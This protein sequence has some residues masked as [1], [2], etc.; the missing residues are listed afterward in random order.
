MLCYACMTHGCVFCSTHNIS[1]DDSP[2]AVNVHVLE[3]PVQITDWRHST[4]HCINRTLH[5][6][7]KIKLSPHEMHYCPQVKCKQHFYFCLR[8]ITLLFYVINFLLFAV[9]LHNTMHTLSKDTDSFTSRLMEPNDPDVNCIHQLK[10]H[11]FEI[12]GYYSND[13]SA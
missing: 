6:C 5:A 7:M 12:S 9:N 1:E 4:C 3:K 13:Q 2:E 8:A 11:S 10:Q